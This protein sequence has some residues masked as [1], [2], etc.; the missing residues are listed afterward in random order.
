[1][2]RT[3]SMTRLKSA[4]FLFFPAFDRAGFRPVGHDQ[5][6]F[7]TALGIDT[8]WFAPGQARLRCPHSSS[9]TK[10]VKGCSR[11]RQ[12]SSTLHQGLGGVEGPVAAFGQLQLGDFQVP[13]G[14]LAP[15]EL[16]NLASGF[17]VL[18]GGKQALYVAHQALQ[19]GPDPGIGQ[20]PIW[21]RLGGVLG[22]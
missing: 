8:G 6:L 9:V 7:P 4:D 17:A 5:G 19:A 21:G 1:M 16:V 13:V 20:G 14:K 11:R 10:G 2:A 18:V 12:V 15:E 3:I 22:A